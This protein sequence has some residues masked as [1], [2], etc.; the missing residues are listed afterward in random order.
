MLLLPE[1][2]VWQQEKEWYREV[3]NSYEYELTDK[4]PKKARDSYARYKNFID[5]ALE[6]ASPY[7]GII[8]D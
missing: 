1:Q 6:G 3:N 2:L 4:A 8:V 5:A 7:E